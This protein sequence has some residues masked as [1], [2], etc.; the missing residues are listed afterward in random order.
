[1]TQ[2]NLITVTLLLVLSFAIRAQKPAEMQEVWHANVSH[3]FDNTGI[4]NDIL[5]GSNDKNYSVIKPST[6]EVMWSSKFK[7]IS[8]KINKIDLQFEVYDARALFMFDKKMGKDQLVV[9][10]LNTGKML[11]HSEKYQNIED[12]EQ[13]FYVP[14]IEAFGIITDKSLNMVKARTGEELWSTDKWNTPVASYMIDRNENSITMINMPKS[15]LGSVF[16]GFKNQIIKLNTQNGN[17]LWENTYSG[18]AQRK[19]ISGERVVS[20]KTKGDKLFLQ[21]NGLQVYDYKTGAPLWKAHFDAT[22]DNVVGRIKGGG[23]VVKKGV[24]GCVADP[25]VDGNDVYVIDMKSRSE[26]YLRKLDINSGKVLWSS[27]EIKDAKV[28]PGLVKINDIIVLQVGGAVE[29]QAQTVKTIGGST[30]TKWQKY[31][32]NVGPYNVQAFKTSDGSQ[33]WQSEKFK[34]GITNITNDE[35]SLIV[36]SGKELYSI[37]YKT[38]SEKYAVELGGDDIKLAQKIINSSD[39]ESADVNK[40]NIIIIG[41]NGVSGHAISNG[42][43]IWSQR[44]KD[45]EF[46]GIYGKTAFYE[47]DNGDVFAIDVN[48]GKAAYYDARKDAK[49]EYSEQGDYLYVF[50]KKKITKLKTN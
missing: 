6:G 2:K 5:Y 50:E 35:N 8:D 4:H 49:T 7:D 27:P 36:C 40:G 29:V 24:Y 47:K 48:S 10:D 39:V 3:D 28:L 21:F 17:V 25:V 14:E 33:V 23:R 16:K 26:Q 34:K 20:L 12:I 46:N 31:Y 38:G 44:I 43:K 11:W 41:E 30:V 22:F 13:V 15:L 18:V 19:V 45:G 32:Q 42:A 37:D 1:M 9:A